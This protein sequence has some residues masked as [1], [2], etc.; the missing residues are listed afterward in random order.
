MKKSQE[1]RSS[2]W[3]TVIGASAGLC[4]SALAVYAI[5]AIRQF[6]LHE[7][8]QDSLM[9]C[10]VVS[11]VLFLFCLFGLFCMAVAV[12]GA[13]ALYGDARETGY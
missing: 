11:G 5:I 1:Y 4:F 2:Y 3:K 10:L 7:G 13:L 12:G 8:A 9:A 6:V